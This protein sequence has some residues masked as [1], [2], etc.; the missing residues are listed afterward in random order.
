M[1][2]DDSNPSQPDSFLFNGKHVINVIDLNKKRKLQSEQLGLPVAKHKCW[3]GSL[4][5]KSISRFVENLEVE[6]FHKNI[7][8]GMAEAET[9]DDGSEEEST[10]ASDSFAEDSDS[11]MSVKGASKF[12]AE[13]GKMWP[14]I[15]P[16]SS[17]SNWGSSSVKE[18][19]YSLEDTAMTGDI[20]KEQ[21]TVVVEKLHSSHYVDGIHIAENLDEPLIDYGSHMEYLC[22]RYDK[23]IMEQQYIDKEIEDFLYS[24]EVNPNIY[25][26]SS[27]RQSGDQEAERGKRKPTIDQEF[28]QYFSTLML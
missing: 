20:G 22:S 15:R 4:P 6:D 8:K 17:S 26:L 28:E 9:T 11:A 16:S 19:R 21:F 10:K 7:I 13:N 12:E 14:H 25:V 27:G 24:N 18:N 1:E 23:N 3:D 5:S 2:P